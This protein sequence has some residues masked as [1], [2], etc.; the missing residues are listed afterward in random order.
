MKKI[1]LTRFEKECGWR[2]YGDAFAPNQHPLHHAFVRG[3]RGHSL[4]TVHSEVEKAAYDR[5]R[6]RSQHARRATPRSAI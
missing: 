4:A 6:L 3:V 5:G 2:E 1:I